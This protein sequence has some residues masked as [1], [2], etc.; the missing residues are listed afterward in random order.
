VDLECVQQTTHANVR[1]DTQAVTALHEVNCYTI[2]K[3][4]YILFY[5][6]CS[7]I[8]VC[9]ENPCQFGGT[10]SRLGVQNTCDCPPATSGDFCEIGVIVY[11][12][13]NLGN[14]ECL[15]S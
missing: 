12:V 7:V 4:L 2:K 13:Q 3:P 11:R 10:C 8:S 15:G 5:A 9:D 1:L 14:K 6:Y